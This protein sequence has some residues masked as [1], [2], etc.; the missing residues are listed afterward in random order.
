MQ[1]YTLEWNS[2]GSSSGPSQQHKN[3]PPTMHHVH[4]STHTQ[5]PQLNTKNIFIPT[6][7]CFLFDPCHLCLCLTWSGQSMSFLGPPHKLLQNSL[8]NKINK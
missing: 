8:K 5:T 7:T 3:N 6:P 1:N 2:Q 4:K